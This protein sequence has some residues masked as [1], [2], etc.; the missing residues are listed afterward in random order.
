MLHPIEIWSLEQRRTRERILS[1]GVLRGAAS[2][3]V[4]VRH[5]LETLV[6]V[7]VFEQYPPHTVRFGSSAPDRSACSCLFHDVQKRD[8]SDVAAAVIDDGS[9]G[10][11]GWKI[12]KR[13]HFEQSTQLNQSEGS[14]EYLHRNFLFNCSI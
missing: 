12:K 4:R 13:S 6:F 10:Q 3:D 14:L 5:H 9:A 2:M 8:G 1:A 11:R 7:Q